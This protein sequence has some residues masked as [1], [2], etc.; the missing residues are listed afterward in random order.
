[1]ADKLY[2]QLLLVATILVIIMLINNITLYKQK[3]INSLSILLI[4]SL[5]VCISDIVWAVL[6]GRLG[7]VFLNYLSSCTNTCFSFLVAALFNKFILDRLDLSIRNRIMK[8]IV[9]V[10]PSIIFVLLCLTTPLTHWVLYSDDNNVMQYMPLYYNYFGLL[11]IIYLGAAVIA[12]IYRIITH[13]SKKDNVFYD[14]RTMEMFAVIA[15]L[16]FF[17]PDRVIGLPNEYSEFSVPW[18]VALVFLTTHLNTGTLINNREKAAVIEADLNTAA[19]IQEDALPKVFPPFPKH[20]E[21]DLYATMSTAKEVGGDFYDCFEVDDH[22]V[23]FLIADVSG[24][25]IPAALFMMICKT[26]IKDYGLMNT[27][28]S[29]IFTDVNKYL[30][31]NNEE[32]MFATAWIGIIDTD[33]MMLQFTNAGH[34]YPYFARKDG[35]FELLKKKHGLF[36]AGMDDTQY[37]NTEIQLSKG[38]SLFLFTDGLTEAHDTNQELFGEERLVSLL[39]ALPERC[40]RT[41]F[42]IMLEAVD[43]YIGN[44][45]QFDDITMMMIN[46]KE[47]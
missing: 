30:S 43:K 21:I 9:Y 11:V 34:N 16:T 23:C 26:M 28:T 38:D 3:M 33:T 27:S 15:L 37:K 18:A 10:I 13:A 14:A 31:E 22:R 40:G 42:P 39:N 47:D 45:E 17:I 2:L 36:L 44:A 8:W 19:R 6:D 1:M 12:A 7:Y 25:G 24:K 5:I 20:P 32:G 29:D 41:A 46:I 35:D 4:F